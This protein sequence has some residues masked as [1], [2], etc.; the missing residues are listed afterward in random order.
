MPQSVCVA[1]LVCIVAVAGM[2]AGCGGGD[3]PDV[4]PPMRVG[5]Y[6]G[7][8]HNGAKALLEFPGLAAAGV[9]TQALPTALVIGEAPL[10]GKTPARNISWYRVPPVGAVRELLVMVQPTADEDT[11]LYL[12]SANGPTYKPKAVSLGYSNRLPA[13]G[14]EVHGYAP[15]WVAFTTEATTGLQTAQVAIYGV[16]T[17]ATPKH[18]RVECDPVWGLTVNGV[19]KNGSLAQYDS[20]W[21]RFAGKMG[22][23]YR[24]IVGATG[25]DPDA[26]AYQGE[27]KHFVAKHTVT[28]GGTLHLTAAA[29]GPY[30]LRLYGF[31]AGN[32]TIRVANP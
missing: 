18:Y 21:Y 8:G 2:L 29:N 3:E 14:D 25:G 9:A 5:E 26:Y 23:D 24:I 22:Q 10:A 28:G 27:A 12:L 4:G 20:R 7:D 15:D 32:Y 13:G 19:T 16:A 6:R 1:G 31:K 17:G 30:Y 11:D